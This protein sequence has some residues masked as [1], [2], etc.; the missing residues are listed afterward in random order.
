M[1]EPVLRLRPAPCSQLDGLSAA[2]VT[3]A[4]A[5]QDRPFAAVAADVAAADAVI[6]A[7]I[8]YSLCG[9]PREPY[10]PLI[11]MAS[12]SR[13]AVISLDL[14]SGVDASTG[15]T[16]GMAVAADA[17][18]ALALPKRGT[19]LGESCRLAGVRYLADIGIPP[20]VFAALGIDV[21]NPFRG[22]P[23]VRLD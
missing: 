1:L 12:V 17:T 22:G 21:A 11:G 15:E 2:E 19:E 20:S 3:L 16:P 8:G 23:M 4:V 10:Q 6:D 5:G 18:L 7:L 9:A 13:G 14:P